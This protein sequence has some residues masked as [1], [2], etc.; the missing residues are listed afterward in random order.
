MPAAT[1]SPETPSRRCGNIEL[2]DAE[3]DELLAKLASRN[4]LTAAGE[5]WYAAHDLQ[6]D[7]LERRL[8]AAELAAAHARL[9]DGYRLRYPGGMADSVTNPYPARALAGHLHDAAPRRRVA[10]GAH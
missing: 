1:H 2:P 3:I 5:S 6:Y 7:A 4:L 10:R 8:S 9:L